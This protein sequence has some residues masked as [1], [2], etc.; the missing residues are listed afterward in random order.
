MR[1]R[2]QSS[3]FW[4]P[5]SRRSR[6]SLDAS[7]PCDPAKLL[8]R[9]RSHDVTSAYRG[10]GRGTFANRCAAEAEGCVAPSIQFAIVEGGAAQPA[11][12]PQR[13]VRHG[14]GKGPSQANVEPLG[15]AACGI[16]HEQGLAGPARGVL[17]GTQQ[18]RADAAPAGA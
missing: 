3:A 12:R 18:R 9:R 2:M 17:G 16:E 5:L 4:A 15:I 14:A 6:W 11:V 8:K 10:C 13:I 1:R 7:T